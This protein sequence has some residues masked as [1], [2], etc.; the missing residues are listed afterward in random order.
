MSGLRSKADIRQAVRSP[1]YRRAR[2][3]TQA[4]LGKR[5]YIRGHGSGLSDQ[6]LKVAIDRRDIGLF[7]VIPIEMIDLLVEKR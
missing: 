1:T 3:P 7:A 5:D 4:R 6:A 2:H